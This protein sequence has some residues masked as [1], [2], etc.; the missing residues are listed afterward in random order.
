MAESR[1]LYVTYIRATPQKIWDCFTDPEM[2]RKFWGGYHQDSSFEVG[3]DYK[4]AGPDGRVWDAGKVLASDPPRLLRLSWRHL[5]EGAMQA[6]GE[7][8][9]TIEIEAAQAGVT[10]LTLTHEIGVAESKLIAG[11][12]TGWPSILSSLKSLLETGEALATA[13]AA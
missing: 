8:I 5:S 12:A 10:T 11:V 7:S 9:C 6:E 1:F 3:G 2:N 4:L 13:K